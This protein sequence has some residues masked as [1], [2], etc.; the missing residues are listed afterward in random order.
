VNFRAFSIF[1]FSCLAAMLL[2]LAWSGCGNRNVRVALEVAPSPQSD[3]RRLVVRAQVTGPQDKLVYRWFSQSGECTP[4][5]TD[6]P[7]TVFAFG[8]NQDRDRIL[9]E[10]WRD[11]RTVAQAEIA[12]QRA[13]RTAGPESQPKL[14]VRIEMTDIPPYDAV[15]G[16]S[17]R[18]HI[19]GTLSGDLEPGLMVV[20][21]ARAK[22]IWFIQPEAATPKLSLR[23]DHS[24]S[25]W[26]H[27]GSEYAVLVVRPGFTP[28]IAVETMP[29][30][31]SG[32]VTQIIFPGEKP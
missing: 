18:A 15:G 24:F 9:V 28:L 7:E 8:E 20:V 31:D 4:Q 30:N 1:L 2:A 21:Y 14:N 13:I 3:A 17:T 26:T 32:I 29:L 5:R 27:T 11:D 12:V 6:T 10:V 22:N 25:N 16:P 23:S 19:G